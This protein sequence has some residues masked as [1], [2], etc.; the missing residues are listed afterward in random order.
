M[1][2]VIIFA[3][4][5]EECEGLLFVDVLRRAEIPITTVS[6]SDSLTVHSLHDVDVKADAL[7]KDVKP[8]DFDVC[9]VPGGFIGMDNLKASAETREFVQAFDKQDKP[10]AA[11]C[12][13]PAVL[14][15]YGVGEGHKVT[16]HFSVKEEIAPTDFVDQ[17]VVEDG[18]LITGNGMAASIP[19]ALALV[20]KM[21]GREARDATAHAIAYVE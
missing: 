14:K 4:G 15:S 3:D 13:G 20:E 8:E 21:K 6:I 17:S 19:A 18:K 7:L 10:I 11:V 12:S 2:A 16:S 1:N 5:F 9:I